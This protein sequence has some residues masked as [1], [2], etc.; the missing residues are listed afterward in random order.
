[1]M[2]KSLVALAALAVVGVASAQS[3][4]TLYGVLDVGFGKVKG[5]SFGLNNG[6]TYLLQ[7]PGG[8]TYA[9]SAAKDGFN[10][11]SVIGFRGSEDLGGGMK[12]NFN[13]QTSGLDLSSSGT[14]LAFG[15][16]A[17]VGLSGGFGEVQ[18]GRSSSVAAKTMGQFDLNG[19]SASSALANA[20]VSAVT[21]Y[22]TSRRSDQLQYASPNMGGFQGRVGLTLKGDATA[23][24]IAV[25]ATAKDRFTLGLGY[26]NGPLAVAGVYETKATS[27]LRNAYA[28]GASFDF[29]VAKVSATYNRR[30]AVG[31]AGFN[32][33]GGGAGTIIGTGGGKGAS[34]G[35]VAPIGAFYVGAQYAKNSDT[36]AKATELFAGYNLSKRTKVYADYGRV[37]G[38]AA[39]AANAS[40]A[41]NLGNNAVPTNPTV[42]GMGVVH[43][44]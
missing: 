13:L 3:S 16:E 8:G 39:V 15:R 32:Q 29:G 17:W 31:V 12:A 34:I 38:V 19:T 14:A 4:V 37:T 11:T 33:L 20:G 44:F 42:F 35:V 41:G 21:W 6:E 28:L 1:M 23:N 10:S 36:N 30:E 9:Q 7:S 22:G 25:P 43:S 26:A 24:G 40:A 2:K 5:G 27:A 18:L